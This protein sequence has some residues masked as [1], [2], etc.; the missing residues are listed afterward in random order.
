HPD[1]EQHARTLA[2]RGSTPRGDGNATRAPTGIAAR[3]QEPVGRNT[4]ARCAQGQL[5]TTMRR[6]LVWRDPTWTHRTFSRMPRADSPSARSFMA[7]RRTRF[8]SKSKSGSTN[9]GRADAA[10]KGG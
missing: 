3:D 1:A 8:K 10:S 9:R 6:G 4:E 2:H 5:L 7:R